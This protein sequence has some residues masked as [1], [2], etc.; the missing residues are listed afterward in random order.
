MIRNLGDHSA[1]ERT[2]LAW[3]RTS[4]AIMAFGFLVEK[5]DL[6]LAIA[7]QTLNA[8]FHLP[9]RRFGNIVG[10]VLI[11]LGVAMIAIAT[12]RFRRTARA[13][14]SAETL[15]LLSSRVDFALALLLILLGLSLFVYLAH[16]L[17]T[18]L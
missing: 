4:V 11:I 18:D 13:I 5:F 2:F 14:D 3:V 6:F 10:L 1:N 16:A 12:L 9:D 8:G 15:P 7:G 17:V